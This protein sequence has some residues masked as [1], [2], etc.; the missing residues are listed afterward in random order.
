MVGRDIELGLLGRAFDRA[1]GG[2]PASVLI[3]GEAGIGKTRLLAEFAQRLDGRATLLTGWCLDYGSIP[4]PYGPLPAIVRGALEA[5]DDPSAEA[6]GP[7]RAALRLLLPELGEGPIDRTA[8]PPEGLGEAIADVFEAAA[9]RHPL[10]VVVE[11]LHW[12]DPATLSILSFLLRALAREQVMFVLTCRTD[13][14]GRGGAVRSFLVAAERA[15]L[16]DRIGLER[17]DAAAVRVL[18]ESLHGGVDDAAFA[19][20]LE[21]S[22]GVPFFVEELACNAEGPIPETLRDVLLARF[23]G[24]GD[25][26]KKVVRL[27]SASDGSVSHDLLTTLSALP[28][29]RLDGAL[30]EA[31]AASILAVRDDDAYA[32]R[33]ALLR[34]AV[35]DDL[36]PGERGR[37]HRAYAEALE[38]RPAD[39]CTRASELAYH[40]HQA[41]DARRALAAAVQAMTQARTDYAFSSAARFGELALELWDQVPDA[42]ELVGVPRI[43]L[44]VRLGSILRNAGDTERS[45]NVIDLAIAEADDD[46]PLDLRVR[47]LRDKA[48]YLQNAGRPGA[49]EYAQK[50]LALMDE[51]FGDQRLRARVLVLLAGRLMIS[52][53]FDESEAAAS[54]AIRIGE[55][56]G[57]DAV[58][59]MS[60]NIIAVSQM[61]RG[62]LEGA[63]A[64]FAR[65][66]EHATDH[67]SRLRY[68]VNYSDALCLL[69]RHHDA[70]RVAEEGIAH[71][72]AVGLERTSGSILTQNLVEP[73]LHLGRIDRVDE[74]LASDLAMPTPRIFR[75][76]T[77][78]SRIKA[79]AWRGRIDEAISLRDEWRSRVD[80]AA[81]VETQVG[82]GRL[83]SAL[84]IEMNAGRADAAADLLDRLLDSPGS[85]PAHFARALTESGWT[86]VALRAQGQDA[87]AAALAVRL[88]DA[89][90][91][92]PGGLRQPRA[93]HVLRALLDPTSEALRAAL[94]YA[95][96]SD[97]P[98]LDAVLVR[99]ELAKSLLAGRGDRAE[100]AEALAEA[101]TIAERVG[102]ARLARDVA[103]FTAASGLANGHARGTGDEL[104]ERERQ[105]LDLIGEGRSNREIADALF[106]SIKTVSVHVSAILRKLGVSSRTEAAAR[107]R[108]GV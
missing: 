37:L 81:E 86:V 77:T 24:L 103:D 10:V 52:A 76:Y 65:S 34:E 104:T 49:I 63:Y 31:M 98:V 19:R 9:R 80:A 85:L 12:A 71:A 64:S 58:I 39:E 27:A 53:R 93:E 91:A 101:S 33:H 59:S 89:W 46:T 25:D 3:G 90:D 30:R 68:R 42:A 4:V 105:V 32:F 13:E 79:L 45:L 107:L 23:D 62:D 87:R 1:G 8:I 74:L 94:A 88:R 40:W 36:L 44:L 72:R 18:A 29:E 26:A 43:A 92:L 69:G 73:L 48:Q 83:L 20:V 99:W 66:W 60:S 28:D 54:E 82:Y 22:E 51:A 96:D 7:G 106:I 61:E 15:R 5:L 55:A 50:S 38:A 21:R 35:H 97:A 14:I 100:A 57:Y 70:I 84:A 17:L 102:H 6:A 41:H 67:D 78:A 75:V 56:I 2:E 16:L 47:L 95:D 108:A 11:D